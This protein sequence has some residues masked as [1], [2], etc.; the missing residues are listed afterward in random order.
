M[1]GPI[2]LV[3]LKRDLR[4]QDHEPLDAAEKAGIPYLILYL[5]E[6]S[7][8]SYPDCSLRH[9]Q[10]QYHSV[11]LLNQ[12]FS[13]VGKEILICHEEADVVFEY[14]IRQYEVE[15]VFSYQE[16]GI[17]IT[18]DRDKTMKKKFE[19]AGIVWK[20]FQR[21]GILRGI[22]NRTHW[23][24]R[25]L[26]KMNEPLV[27]NLYRKE[28]IIPFETPFPLKPD[29]LEQLKNYPSSFQPPGEQ[30]AQKYL[31]SFLEERGLNYSKHI[32][33]PLLSRKSC[34]RLSPY[35][36]WGNISIRQVYQQTRLRLQKEGPKRPF[37]NFLSR[38]QWH[39]HF[40]Q[41]FEMDCSY[42]N[43][44]INKGYGNLKYSE[45]ETLLNAWKTGT[46]GV[47]IVDACM[48]CLQQTGWINFRMR[49]MVVSFLS[50]HLF[51]DW[52][53]G[54]HHLAG[55]FLDYE[56]GIHYPQ[57]QMQAGTTGVNTI[58][59]YNPVKNSLEHDPEGNFI[60]QWVTELA[61][62]PLAFIHQ[63]WLMTKMDE[64]LYSFHIGKD[65]PAPVIDLKKDLRK[66]VDAL[67]TLRQSETVKAENTRI[68]RTHTRN[69]TFDK[70]RNRL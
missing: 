18:Y 9:L 27:R 13:S 7:I 8:I 44:S 2:N 49:A 58:R 63:P 62:L 17:Q 52:R 23:D 68:I 25:W 51:L 20:E 3:W 29:L 31:T 67:W 21:D 26:Q 30:N 28:E 57:F 38:I 5:F 54:A 22:K 36:A 70:R 32:S 40:I 66:N 59:V 24:T 56:P 16:S 61:H 1:T 14:L 41:K 11:L 42:E 45:S 55:L 4:S 60:K 69:S 12:F 6:P 43:E 53:K 39:C 47:P 65:Y 35:L 50:H 10:F 37:E 46:T 64:M 48:R 15:T 19:K 33:K 34:A